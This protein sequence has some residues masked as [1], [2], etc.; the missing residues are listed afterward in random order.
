MYLDN[1]VYWPG[2]A[3]CGIQMV[4]H[5]IL[6]MSLRCSGYQIKEGQMGKGVGR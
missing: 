2:M 1:Y 5:A 4:V 6:T 3:S